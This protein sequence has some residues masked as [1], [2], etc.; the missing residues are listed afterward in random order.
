MIDRAGVREGI[1]FVLETGLFV[2]WIGVV[3]TAALGG[4][5]SKGF[6]YPDRQ[7]IRRNDTARCHLHR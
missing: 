6:W 5:M 2:D 4:V 1:E 3:E 7:P